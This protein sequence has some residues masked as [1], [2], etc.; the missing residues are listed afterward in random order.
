MVVAVL[1]G[2]G[3]NAVLATFSARLCPRVPTAIHVGETHMQLTT[4]RKSSGCFGPATMQAGLC[5]FETFWCGAGGGLLLR[6][7][8]FSAI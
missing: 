7:R 4:L 5:D 2:T 1:Q 6:L 8:T 3:C